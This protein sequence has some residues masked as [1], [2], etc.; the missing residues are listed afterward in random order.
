M[1][2]ALNSAWNRFGGY[3]LAG[4]LA[5]LP[6]V[7]TVAIV[8]WVATF[9]QSFIGRD[10]F[11]GKVLESLGLNFATNPIFAYLIGWTMVL[12]GVWLLGLFVELGAKRVLQRLV[13]SI[14]QRVPIINAVYNTSRQ[15]VEMFDR[16][17]QTELK[18]MSAVF[19]FFGGRGGPGVLAL[20]PTAERFHIQGQDYHVV[21]IPTAPVPFGGGMIFM[22]ADCVEPADMPVEGLMSVYVSM[23]VTASQFLHKPDSGPE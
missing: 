10:T 22:P 19:C 1:H 9:L 15:L 23:G 7:L 6:L 17:Q 2:R 14:V 13:D 3:F 18:S 12:V 21:I 5:V 4:L 20:M 16:K 11:L 8:A